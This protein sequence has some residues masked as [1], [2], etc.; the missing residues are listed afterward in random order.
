M[1]AVKSEPACK[2]PVAEGAKRP[3]P[4]EFKLGCSSLSGSATSKSAV[5]LTLFDLSK[6]FAVDALGCSRASF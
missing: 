3:E 6:S 5:F 2:L 4:L 1:S